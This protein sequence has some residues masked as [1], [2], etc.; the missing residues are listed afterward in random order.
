VSAGGI[1][2]AVG[3]VISENA[4][5]LVIFFGCTVLVV[6][7]ILA[8][9]V[10]P[11]FVRAWTAI[12]PARLSTAWYVARHGA[13]ARLTATTSTI[14]PFMIG[15]GLLSIYF[16]AATTSAVTS[17][18]DAYAPQVVLGQGLV[19]FTPGAV[20]A[21]AGSVAIVFMVGQT[22][23]R[24]TALLRATGATPRTL[25]L[26]PV[27]EALIYAATAFFLSAIV[28]LLSV[29]LYS[30]SLVNQGYEWSPQVD[31]RAGAAVTL[32]GF[33]GIVLAIGILS[34]IANKK[35]VREALAA[36]Q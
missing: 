3:A 11:V 10:F 18:N 22:R 15:A 2:F 32:V 7:A 31:L 34:R 4:S 25:A 35:T 36:D 9:A 33:L 6:F 19:L 30:L 8:S 24:E 23:D 1:F 26:M 29:L 27:L 21:I 16:S 20:I 17:R 12:V 13:L 28:A 5:S 14:T